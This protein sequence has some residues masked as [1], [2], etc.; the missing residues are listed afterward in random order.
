MTNKKESKTETDNVETKIATP[1][2]NILFHYKGT[3]DD[4]ELFD[5]SRKGDS[6]AA[7]L[8]VLLGTNRLLEAFENALVGMKA[9]DV[10]SI[11]LNPLVKI[12]L[13]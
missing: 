3:Y 13:L 12:L 1:G 6:D 9:G 7:P 11:S 8:K 2:T 4:G 10:K 5:D